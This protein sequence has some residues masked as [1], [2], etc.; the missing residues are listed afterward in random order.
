MVSGNGKFM[1]IGI[2]LGAGFGSALG[3]IFKNIPVGVAIGCAFGVI[4]GLILSRKN[5]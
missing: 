2:A 5:A 4:L 1:G 3:V